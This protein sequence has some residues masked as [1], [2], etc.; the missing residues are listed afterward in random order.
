MEGAAW[1]SVLSYGAMAMMIHRASQKEYAIP[2]N[3][4]AAF[5]IM[6]VCG[7]TVAATVFVPWLST[8]VAKC[9]LL[10]GGSA[11]VAAITFWPRKN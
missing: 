4:A 9:S 8:F 5:L 10:L 11:I 1:A 7:S 3:M 6:A 2:Y